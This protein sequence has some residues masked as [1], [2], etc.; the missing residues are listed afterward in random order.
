MRVDVRKRRVNK[1]A[2]QICMTPLLWRLAATC[3]ELEAV[4]FHLPFYGS[5]DMLLCR[6]LGLRVQSE[7]PI[8]FELTLALFLPN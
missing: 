2:V 1:M 4:L 5:T 8:A 3:T 6:Q 7:F